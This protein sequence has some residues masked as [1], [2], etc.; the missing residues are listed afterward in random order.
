MRVLFVVS[1]NRNELSPI[2]LNQAKSL[3]AYSPDIHIDFFQIKGKGIFGYLKNCPK[4]RRFANSY[5]PDVIHA[6]YS[7]AGYLAAISL[8]PK[9][10]IVSLMG[11]DANVSGLLKYTINIVSKCL[12]SKVIV[13]SDSMLKIFN[14]KHVIVLPNGVDFS[15]FKRIAKEKSTEKVGF[16]ITK[17]QIV[18]FLSENNR[19]EKN[20]DLAI[21]AVSLMN[22]NQIDFHII[23]YVEHRMVP[24]LLNAA[25]VLLLTSIYE[26]SP[27]IIKE[28]MACDLPIVSTDVGDVSKVIKNTEGCYLCSYNPEDVA[29]KLTLALKFN[30]KTNGRQNISHLDSKSIAKQLI[31]IYHEVY[32]NNETSAPPKKQK[33]KKN[34]S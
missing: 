29:E 22:S 26:G 4:L 7:Y 9:K 21:K 32:E 12:W 14:K 1:G 19:K 33:I 27:N 6:H 13:K 18:F 31:S 8:F 23:P 25:D 5:C 15:T 3:M 20:V 17:K 11:S 30:K 34:D 16:D 2:V 10:I 28:A 24:Y